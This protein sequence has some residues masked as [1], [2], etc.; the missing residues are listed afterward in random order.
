MKRIA[1]LGLIATALTAI[2]GT[3]LADITVGVVVSATGPAASLGIPEKNTVALMPQTMGG[4]KVNYVILDDASDTTAAVSNTRKLI[5]ENKADIIIGSSTTPNS[6]A[7]IDVVAE[8]KTPMIT[9]GAS[10]RIISPMDDKK[11]WVFKTPQNDSMMAGAIV[12]HMAKSGVKTVGFIGFNDAYGE[13]WLQEFKKSAEA[14]GIKVIAT[15]AFSRSDTS[16]TGQALKIMGAKPDAVL[17]AGSGTPAALPEKTLKERGYKGKYYQTHGVANA[18]F[19]RVGGKDVEGT[20]LPAGP[21]LVSHQLPDAHPVKKA[22]VAYVDAYE[23]KY[24]KG[25]AATFGAH[26]WDAGKVL[27]AA[28]PEALKKG[29]PGTVEFRTALRDAMEKTSGVAGAHGVFTMSPTDHLGIQHGVVMVKIENGT[30]KY[31]P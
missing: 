3:A 4:Q 13:G 8:G 16:V 1:K 7:M 26:T 15:E 25:T 19:L 6:L 21:V 27:E 11:K 2:W 30:W 9:L 23:T 14:K 29:Q 10:A 31:Q 28:V 24:G 20:L 17:V 18:D 12:D 5:S 22:A